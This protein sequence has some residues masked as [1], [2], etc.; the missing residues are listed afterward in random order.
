M[1]LY[2]YINKSLHEY[3]EKLSIV[4][5]FPSKLKLKTNMCT[6]ST[7]ITIPIYSLCTLEVKKNLDGTNIKP[8]SHYLIWFSHFIC[9][10]ILD[11][12]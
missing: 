6:P 10:G 1:N 4:L 5:H 3:K 9:R 7:G 8:H 11:K 12:P 2:C